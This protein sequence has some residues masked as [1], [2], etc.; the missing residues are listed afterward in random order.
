[1][2]INANLPITFWPYVVTVAVYITN[3]TATE[4]IIDKKRIILY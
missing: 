4:P 3:I 1:M 2:L